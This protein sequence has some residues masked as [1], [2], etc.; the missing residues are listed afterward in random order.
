MNAEGWG[1]AIAPPAIIEEQLTILLQEPRRS[2]NCLSS[3]LPTHNAYDVYA[4]SPRS[5]IRSMRRRSSILTIPSLILS[6]LLLASCGDFQDPAS[7]G[8]GAPL[9]YSSVTQVPQQRIGGSES[10]VTPA[11]PGNAIDPAS[12][13]AS[14]DTAPA[15]TQTIG[16]AYRGDRLA[17]E[18][19]SEHFSPPPH[20]ESTQLSPSGGENMPPWLSRNG[21]P[22]ELIGSEN[23]SHTKPVTF[24]MGP[25]PLW[26]RGRIQTLRHDGISLGAIYI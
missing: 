25:L 13:P 4:H 16:T 26:K 20:S 21:P 7:G 18:S 5:P 3:M 12:L 15:S 19:A 23:R 8:Q 9:S 11:L 10:Q 14:T 6:G 17:S 1:I 24:N 22:S 2:R